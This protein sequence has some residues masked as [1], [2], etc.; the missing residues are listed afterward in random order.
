MSRDH[1][2]VGN[3]VYLVIRKAK[4][5]FRGK[6]QGGLFCPK[7]QEIHI[8]DGIPHND[9]QEYRWEEILHTVEFQQGLNINHKHLRVLAAA[10]PYILRDNPYMRRGAE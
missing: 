6:E 1:L 4:I 7:E 10:I 2:K 9:E 5:I 8:L 3:I